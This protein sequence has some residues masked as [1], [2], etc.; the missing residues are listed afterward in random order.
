MIE[1]NLLPQKLKKT[2]KKLGLPE[3]P[4]V[5]IAACF[6]GALILVQ[7]FLSGLIF[8]SK[9]QLV[10]LEKTWKIL[11][12]EKAKLDGIK[13]EIAS[14]NRMTG[15]IDSL[16]REQPS[17]ACLLNELSNSLTA[18][19]WLTEL[20]YGESLEK[21]VPP[22][23][24]S[25]AGTEPDEKKA[26]GPTKAVQQKQ[27]LIGTLVLSGFA[28]GLGEEPTANVA[29][30]IRS[31]KKNAGFFKDF[32]DVELVSMEKSTVEGHDVMNFTLTCRRRMPGEGE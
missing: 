5:P 24:G 31:L 17:W 8:I 30:F 19:I 23:P 16:M 20:A 29:R 15:V 9:R 21:V 25:L 7:I 3:I 32:L 13:K 22:R 28:S 1:L 14:G 26:K 2:K 27:R 10:G 11:A 6:V 18:N 4:L 12:P